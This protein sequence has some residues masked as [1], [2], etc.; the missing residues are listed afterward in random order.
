VGL[1]S[2]HA[3]DAAQA[4]DPTYRT[5]LVPVVPGVPEEMVATA[6]HLAAGKGAMIGAITVL[7]VPQDLPLDAPMPEAEAEVLDH[8]QRVRRIAEGY[9]ARVV[10][11]IVRGRRAGRAIVEEAAR[12][13]AEVIMLRVPVKRRVGA[14]ALGPTVDYVLAN[15]PCRVLLS[16]EPS[17]RLGKGAVPPTSALREGPPPSP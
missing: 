3:A 10:T 12:T 7:E 8:L 5:I 14:S 9:G 13:N 2:R 4:H 16:V 17:P 1:F 6:G 15:A 11:Y